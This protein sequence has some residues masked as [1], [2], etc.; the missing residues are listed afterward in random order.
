MPLPFGLPPPD[1]GF[2]LFVASHGMSE[3]L[4]QTTGPQ[5]IPRATVRSGSLQI[6]AQW[7]N[8][9]SPIASG[10]AALFVKWSRK[11]GRTQL[12][13][14]AL[15]RLR[16]D[17]A[18]RVDSDAWELDASFRRSFGKLG[19][20]G[21]VEYAPREF[22]AGKSLYVELGPNFR[23]GKAT[24]LSVNLGR[25]E[26]ARAPDYTT[27]NAGLTHGVGDKLSLD[28]RIYGTDHPERG[29]RYRTRLIVSARLTL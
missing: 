13:L 21:I 10:I 12:E 15:Y 24:T 6:G 8:I 7:R 27:I 20:R 11:R 22:E 9:S 4:S 17:P 26:R 25:R 23:V 14:A 28:A 1:P 29:M 16:T 5:I 2:E 3:G 19:L 18:P